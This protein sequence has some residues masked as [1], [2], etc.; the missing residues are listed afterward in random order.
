MGD[1]KKTSS[2]NNRQTNFQFLPFFFVPQV[3]S[4]RRIKTIKNI[5]GQKFLSGSVINTDNLEK[6]QNT[7]EYKKQGFG[8]PARFLSCI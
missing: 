5:S 7:I 4:P 6:Y 1:V 3:C 8:Y 2:N